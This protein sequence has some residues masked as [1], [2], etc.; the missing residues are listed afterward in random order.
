MTGNAYTVVKT[1]KAGEIYEALDFTCPKDVV[2]A[3]LT[4]ISER[5]NG[6]EFSHGWVVRNEDGA[7]QVAIGRTL[8]PQP[9]PF[10]IHSK[11]ADVCVISPNISYEWYDWIENGVR[12][13]STSK[14]AA[15]NQTIVAVLFT[16]GRFEIHKVN[17]VIDPDFHFFGEEILQV[18]DMLSIGG[19]GYR[20]DSMVYDDPV[21]GSW[22]L[23]EDQPAAGY[24]IA[25]DWSVYYT[26]I[27]IY[28]GVIQGR[29]RSPMPSG[30][31]PDMVSMISGSVDL[32]IGESDS[33]QAGCNLGIQTMTYADDGLTGVGYATVKDAEEPFSRG[34]FTE[35][36][37]THKTKPKSQ[38][39]VIKPYGWGLDEWRYETTSQIKANWLASVWYG[40]EPIYPGHKSGGVTGGV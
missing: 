23:V 24:R 38:S 29:I 18:S 13:V 31:I 15:K 11:T 6:V 19:W 32:P 35:G 2:A 4:M 10:S 1:L 30:A 20:V 5:E 27:R 28:Q 8:F 14:A 25:T 3:R 12:L 21:G 17:D 40:P 37:G 16:G 36:Q 9:L 22:T 34:W 26:P 39:V 7:D 33:S